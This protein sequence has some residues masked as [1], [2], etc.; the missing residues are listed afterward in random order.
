MLT[1][2]PLQEQLEDFIDILGEIRKEH[3]DSY[4]IGVTT[5]LSNAKRDIEKLDQVIKKH[6]L[7]NASTSR[8]RRA[9]WMRYKSKICRLQ[10]SLKEHRQNI[11]VVVSAKSLT[12]ATRS[13]T[14]LMFMSRDVT[15]IKDTSLRV[16]RRLSEIHSSLLEARPRTADLSQQNTFIGMLALLGVYEYVVSK[17]FHSCIL[18]GIIL[19]A[20]LERSRKSNRAD[21]RYQIVDPISMH[22]RPRRINHFA[23]TGLFEQSQNF[24]PETYTTNQCLP[25]YNVVVISAYEEASFGLSKTN[26]YSLFYLKSPRELRRLRITITIS[27][28]SMYWPATSITRHGYSQKN[29][30]ALILWGAVV[31]PYALTRQIQGFLAD[32]MDLKDGMHLC[33]SLSN[34]S[35][36]RQENISMQHQEYRSPLVPTPRELSNTSQDILTFLDDL[37][38]PRYF[39]TEVQRIA[40]IEPCRFLA[41]FNGLLVEEIVFTGFSPNNEQL[42]N[43]QVLHCMDGISG[44]PKL[45]GVTTDRTG[46]RLKSYLVELP[47]K[48]T[49]LNLGASQIYRSWSHVENLARQ[50]VLRIS[51]VHSRGL[52]VGKVYH[53]GQTFLVDDSN[54][55]YLRT[56]QNK[57][58]EGRFQPFSYPPE[59]RPLKHW[60]RSNNGAN[61]RAILPK[62]DIFHLGLL[63]WLLAENVPDRLHPFC[64]R[65]SCSTPPDFCSDESH[66]DP[67]ALPRLP[68]SVPSYFQDIIDACRAEE[69]SQRPPA[70]RLLEMFPPLDDSRSTL[71]KSSS[72]ADIDV[73]SLRVNLAFRCFYCSCCKANLKSQSFFHCSVC[74]EGDFDICQ[75]CYNRGLHCG[76]KEHMLVQ[77][78]YQDSSFAAKIYHSSVKDSGRREIT[79]F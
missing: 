1:L 65:K 53:Y 37:G 15:L 72:V 32:D 16:D 28:S 24:F 14:A 60:P 6:I 51:Q 64:R 20:R 9:A 77:F 43:I 57:V 35:L 36:S 39:E 47:K 61:A 55:L 66:Y 11:V 34:K 2:L 8:A 25:R 59:H 38:C 48:G 50:I 45:V 74:N 73:H 54:C 58:E 23:P 44:F 17:T 41:C 63:L 21:D 62:W 3:S 10:D 30:Q 70:W 68:D 69:P 5:S 42:Y 4:S 31:L 12:S 67:V 71:V 27:R 29:G 46:T 49:P 75:S 52:V 40:F 18:G 13:E 78:E 19:L 22:A 56:F 33:F 26:T 79:T 7:P 76:D